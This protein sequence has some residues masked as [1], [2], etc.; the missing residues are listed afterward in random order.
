M[1]RDRT[2]EEAEANILAAMRA[3]G[4]EPVLDAKGE[5]DMGAYWSDE[6]PY[7]GG[8]QCR[9]CE[10]VWCMHCDVPEIEQCPGERKGSTDGQPL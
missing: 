9:F 2:L 10:D 1:I 5:P 7:H 4:H 3:K 6:E 8:P